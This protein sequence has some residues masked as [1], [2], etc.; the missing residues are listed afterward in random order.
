MSCWNFIKGYR[1]SK[2]ATLNN[3]LTS[4][5]NQLKVDET[6]DKIK[7]E[8]V[9]ICYLCVRVKET[10]IGKDGKPTKYDRTTHVDRS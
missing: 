7:A 8:T 10:Y 4:Y 9:H 6:F 1:F 2:K 3:S 5:L